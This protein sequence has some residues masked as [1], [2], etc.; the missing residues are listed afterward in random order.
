MITPLSF[1]D[2]TLETDRLRLTPMQSKDLDVSKAVLCDARV[3]RYVNDAMLPD[4]VCDRSLFAH[5]AI[6]V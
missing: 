6:C 3:M 1:D 2:L 5:C 4:A